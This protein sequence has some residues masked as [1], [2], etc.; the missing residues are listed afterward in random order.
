M[1]AYSATSR[2]PCDVATFSGPTTDAKDGTPP[3][4][5]PAASRMTGPSA[6]PVI[7]LVVVHTPGRQHGIHTHRVYYSSFID[8]ARNP[9]KFFML[10]FGGLFSVFAPRATGPRRQD[11][12]RDRLGSVRRCHWGRAHQRFSA[13]SCCMTRPCRSREGPLA[14]AWGPRRRSKVDK[15]GTKRPLG[16]VT[17]AANSFVSSVVVSSNRTFESRNEF[18]GS[19]L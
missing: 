18:D 4:S 17:W 6:V 10:R 11:S 12:K 9:S 3:I 8:D 5:P 15:T 2:P 16:R 7:V 1:D 14:Q 19:Q 13:E